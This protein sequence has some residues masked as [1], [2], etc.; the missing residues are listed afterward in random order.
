MV[1][2]FQAE[3][4]TDVSIKTKENNDASNEHSK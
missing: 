1:K 2:Q 4:V 3:S